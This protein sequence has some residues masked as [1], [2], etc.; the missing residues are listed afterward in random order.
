MNSDTKTILWELCPIRRV[1]QIDGIYTAFSRDITPDYLFRGEAHDFYEIEIVTKGCV[2]IT[3]GADSLI[4]QAPSAILHPPMEFHSLRAIG[5]SPAQLVVF[6]FSASRMPDFS[7][8]IFS[9]T[10]PDTLRVER[11]LEL[12]QKSASYRVR[13]NGVVAPEREREAQQ[14]LCELE[15]LL[16]SLCEQGV[17]ERADCT[18]GARN[19]RKILQTIEQNISLPLDIVTLA[20]LT[21][22]SPSLLKKTFSRYA[23]IG[24]MQYCRTQKC[25]TAIRM[26]R[27]GKSVKETALALGFC[28]A[29]YFATAFR[30][31]T[32]HSPTYYRNN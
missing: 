32:G 10:Q 25:N 28:D 26:L 12:L 7:H 20:R 29:A 11:A 19:Y 13:Q 2:S 27:E 16:L 24:V 22:M 31:T 21:Q 4:L 23:G 9:L 17:Q 3:A 18:A 30:R 1:V 5:D 14:G 8:R 6:S 15:A